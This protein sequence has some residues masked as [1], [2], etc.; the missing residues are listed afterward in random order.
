MK[1]ILAKSNGTTLI[2][3]SKNVSNIAVKISKLS[4]ETL[5][6]KDISES[7]RIIGLLHDI[8]KITEKLQCIYYKKPFDETKEQK[9][10][11]RHN[12]VG[13]AF[14][15]RYLNLPNNI[16]DYV[17]DGVYWHHGI[18]NKMNSYHDFDVTFSDTDKNRMI[19]YVKTVL[20]EEYIKEES[21]K[22][23]E[24]PKYYIDCRIGEMTNAIKLFI[25]GCIISA[26]RLVSEIEEKNG[27]INTIDLNIIREG[28]IDL[29]THEYFGNERFKIQQSISDQVPNNNTTII[30][31]PAGYGKTLLGFI[32]NIISGNKKLIWVC[33]RNVIADGVY[34]SF[35]KEISR[36]NGSTLSVELYLSGN[37]VE[38]NEHFK[39]DFTSDIIITNIDNFLSPS[40]DN[41]YAGRLYT[42]FYSDVVLDEFH[43]TITEEPLFACLVN[44]LTVKHRLTNSK[45][46]M[47]S[48]TSGNLHKLWDDSAKHLNKKTV[49]LPENGKHY[50]SPF[51]TKFKINVMD[52]FDIKKLNENN[53]IIV[54][55]I[56]NAQILA[57]DLNSNML[58][59]S[60]F[61]D[62][63][64]E[65]NID[66]L[67]EEFGY[68]GEK[69][70]GKSNVVGTPII[71][72]SLDVSLGHLYE[73]VLSPEG[74]IQRSGRVVRKGDYQ[75]PD[76]EYPTINIIWF[77]NESEEATRSLLYDN[78]LSRKW[79]NYMKQYDQKIVT[80]NGLY[81]IYNRYYESHGDEIYS[82]IKLKYNKSLKS[83]SKCHPVKYYNRRITDI[84]IAGG[85]K[86][87][88]TGNE[89]FVTC[90]NYITD[91][92]ILPISVTV[93][94]SFGE[95][96]KENGDVFKKLIDTMRVIDN[97]NFNYDSILKRKKYIN[98]DTIRKSA[99]KSDTPYIRFDRVYHPFYGI[100]KECN[101]SKLNLNK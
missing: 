23:R 64:R 81:E 34:R 14:L 51:D 88:S 49:I 99:K 32:N 42:L 67:Y 84:K 96:F 25:R 73:S 57:S 13:W 10:P 7:I 47:L 39:K 77:D 2:E 58:I 27:D 24:A 92:Y 21:E 54:N 82:H 63:D 28:E 93:E 40:I 59:H 55:S 69:E 71:Q 66:K 3:H 87:R 38:H 8:D 16:L 86:L 56:D 72:A 61:S 26:D 5:V 44:L 45:T 65:R 36:C 83:L 48:A 75:F 78:R 94:G 97:E 50:H 6:D 18:T 31:A 60:Q 30:N 98:I 35:I 53:L 76:G 20:G 9:L 22:S 37:V 12:E 80:I 90:K 17:L 33:P 52:S 1:K 62:E 85:N 43:E 41:S 101:L 19:D 79:F 70:F 15:S 89:I 95:F 100:V 74:T 91:D 46:V 4:P 11:Y 68:E 29:T